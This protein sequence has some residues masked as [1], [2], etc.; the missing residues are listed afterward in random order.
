MAQFSFSDE[1]PQ[2]PSASPPAPAPATSAPAAPEPPAEEDDF[3]FLSQPPLASTPASGAPTTHAPA[4]Q[5]SAPASNA[6][7]PGAN[8]RPAPAPN[9]PRP[10]TPPAPG[11]SAP[12]TPAPNAARPANATAPGASARP[13]PRPLQPAKPKVVTEGDE[14]DATFNVRNPRATPGAAPA[15]NAPTAPAANIAA[16]LQAPSQ[17]ASKVP[18]PVAAATAHPVGVPNPAAAPN[19]AAAQALTPTPTTPSA[20]E[21]TGMETGDAIA[22]GFF[23]IGSAIRKAL[24]ML[25]GPATWALR[26]AVPIGALCLAYIL[27]ASFLG[28]AG[29]LEGNAKAAELLRNLSYASKG[30]GV[31]LLVAAVATLLLSYEDNKIGAIMVGLGVL[32][33]FGVILGFKAVLGQSLA[34]GTIAAPL[35]QAGMALFW[36]GAVK[37]VIDLFDFLWKLPDRVRNRQADVGKG[38]PTEAKQR[39][40]ASNANMFSECWKLPFCREAIRVLCPAFIAKKTCWKFG[41]GC[42]CDEEMIG[43]IVRGEPMAVISAPTRVSQS[44]PPCGRCYI[45]LEH[46]TY[47][48]RMLSPLAL[49]LTIM[50]AYFGYPIYERAFHVFDKGLQSVW[51]SFSFNPAALTPKAIAADPDAAAAATKTAL[52]AAQVAGFAQAIIGVMLGFF[53]L[54]Y[55]SK[56]IEWAIFKA[57]L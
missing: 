44:K 2:A 24:N 13:A 47:K 3:S 20:E 12:Q 27:A 53:L 16:P 25:E 1:E 56:G 39:A 52:D 45:Y 22:A 38:R 33:Q 17:A 41:R 40:I 23:G 51:N 4:N 15:A 49:P 37:A 42:Y 36:I 46:Q 29:N 10:A 9:T 5:A 35:R 8:A 26:V 31:A 50:V 11:T 48:F 34:V 21:V 54:V 30:L 6:P 55:I 18:L 14:S 7:A 19:S 57:K 28:G 43:R 32:L